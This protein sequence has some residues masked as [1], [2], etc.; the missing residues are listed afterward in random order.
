MPVQVTPLDR[1]LPPGEGRGEGSMLSTILQLAFPPGWSV[2]RHLHENAKHRL[3][4]L[5]LRGCEEIE[6]SDTAGNP[7]PRPSPG[8]RG[9]WSG[10]ICMCISFAERTAR[11]LRMVLS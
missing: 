10:V 1:P 6:L 8:G 2:G 11:W 3:S 5:I 7:S 9:R 4:T